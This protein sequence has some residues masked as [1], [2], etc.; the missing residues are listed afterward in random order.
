[1]A[2]S[3][4]KS[5]FTKGSTF[6][7]VPLTGPHHPEKIVAILDGLPAK[8][9]KSPETYSPLVLRSG[10]SPRLFTLYAAA[11]GFRFTSSSFFSPERTIEASEAATDEYA[12]HRLVEP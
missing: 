3:S 7:F 12:Q 8:D 9:V 6:A 11:V 5:E 2:F 4:R 10:S 1:M